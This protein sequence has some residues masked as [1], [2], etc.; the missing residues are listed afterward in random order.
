[1]RTIISFQCQGR[2]VVLTGVAC[3]RLLSED[4][5]GA[6]RQSHEDGTNSTSSPSE[7]EPESP[8]ASEPAL[9]AARGSSAAPFVCPPP[10][11]YTKLNF[12]V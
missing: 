10:R 11:C 4:L 5:E 12:T 3:S 1:M 6:A 7:P 8:D 2:L 9:S